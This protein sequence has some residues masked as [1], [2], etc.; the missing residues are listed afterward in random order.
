MAEAMETV[1]FCLHFFGACHCYATRKARVKKGKFQ[2]EFRRMISFC[3]F[4]DTVLNVR[5]ERPPH[6]LS[7]LLCLLLF[8]EI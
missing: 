4:V 8:L 3:T 7:E 2:V 6:C 1:I 5:C